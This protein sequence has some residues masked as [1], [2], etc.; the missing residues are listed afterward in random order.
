MSELNEKKDALKRYHHGNLRD[1][2]VSEARRLISKFGLDR[3][4]IADACRC[5]GVSTAAPYRHFPDRD[6]LLHAVCAQAFVELGEELQKARAKHPRGSVDAVIEIGKSYLHFVTHDPELFELLW[7][8]M[9]ST[10]DAE[11]EAEAMAIGSTCFQVLIDAVEDVLKAQGLNHIST[12]DVALPL[13][14][15][16]QGLA[17]LQMR[18][19]LRI[20]D[21]ADPHRMIDMTVRAIFDGFRRQALQCGQCE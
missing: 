7:G 5:L 15:F 8:S 13:W 16:V 21:N 12:I 4:K 2:L 14:S 9:R 19:K 1:A 17:S 11:A 3:F 18:N 6:A 20:V 10:Q